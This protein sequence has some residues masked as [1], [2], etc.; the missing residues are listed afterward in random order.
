M[1][2]NSDNKAEYQLFL[3][4]G[5]R[6]ALSDAFPRLGLSHSVPGIRIRR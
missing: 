2:E 6:D 4:A 5:G 3:Q 1:I